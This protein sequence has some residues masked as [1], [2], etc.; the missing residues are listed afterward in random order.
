MRTVL[1]WVALAIALALP[2]GL[3]A[4][5][6]LLA[7][8]QPIYI[9]AALAGI[10]GMGLLVVQPLLAARLLSGL[11]PRMSRNCHRLTGILLVVLVVSHVG[12]LWVTS[13]PDVIDALLFRSPTLFTP[14]GVIG[15]WGLFGAAALALLRRFGSGRWKTAHMGLATLVALCTIPHA[16][17]IDGT[18]E[19]F[20]KYGLSA[21]ILI[22]TVLAYRRLLA[23]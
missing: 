12:G 7:Y 1:I 11:S 2:L 18:M 23:K 20:S 6:P 4:L 8:R 17:L 9:A 14:F 13:P 5:S 15:M 22:V 3:A 19:T 10:A 21:L 16:L